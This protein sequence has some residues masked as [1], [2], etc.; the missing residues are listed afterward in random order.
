MKKKNLKKQKRKEQIISLAEDAKL[1]IIQNRLLSEQIDNYNKHIQMIKSFMNKYTQ[2][3]KLTESISKD[4]NKSK[5][6]KN[7][8]IN[9]YKENAE[10]LNQLEIDQ[11]EDQINNSDVGDIQN[12]N[13]ASNIALALSKNKN[14]INK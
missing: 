6:I 8:F 13:S 7:E 4:N 2:N 14:L 12:G 5:F 11:M 10:F 1:K 3:N 9:Y